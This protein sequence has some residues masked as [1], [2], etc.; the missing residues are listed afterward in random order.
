MKKFVCKVCG[1]VYE[2]ETPLLLRSIRHKPEELAPYKT[3]L[4]QFDF[5]YNLVDVEPG[6]ITSIRIVVSII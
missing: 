1:Y 4:D 5:R 3:I 2:G 6:L